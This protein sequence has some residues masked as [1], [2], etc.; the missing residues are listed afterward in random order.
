MKEFKLNII[1]EDATIQNAL[2]NLNNGA[3]KQTLFVVDNNDSLI[4]TLTDGDIRRA[5]LLGEL[6]N[7]PIS[8]A[9]NKDCLYLYENSLTPED[10]IKCKKFKLKIIPIVNRESKKIKQLIQLE[11]FFNFLPIQAVIMAGGK[12][13]RLRPLTEKIPKP[14]LK[15][16]GKPILEYNI[17]RLSKFGIQ[18]INISLNYLGEVIS[19]Y[20]K[21]GS[22]R[23]IQI[24]YTTETK[25]LGTIGA[26]KLIKNISSDI[27]LVMNSDLL[28][29]IDYG[30]MYNQ[31][32]K[33][34]SDMIMATTSYKVKI[35]Y[36][37]L[38][39]NGNEVSSFIEKPT[40]DYSTNAGIYLIKKS[41][42]DLIPKDKEFNATDLIDILISKK[43][44]VTHYPILG[45]WLDIGK[46]QDFSKAQEDIHHLKL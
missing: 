28:T 14:M 33:D 5:L 22:D 20:F 1:K 15:I 29:N 34:N 3:L 39:T 45:Y 38:K 8:T 24:N 31:F 40:M 16:G 41:S 7:K 30:E 9:I 13:M 36:A 44:K 17:D 10:Y 32:L 18:N 42:L 43:K 26:L 35:P 23:F 21:D 4:G 37:V 6:I 25:P 46:P 12:G 11:D 2:E 27:I 19:N